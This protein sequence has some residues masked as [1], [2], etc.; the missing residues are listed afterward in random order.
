VSG[1]GDASA[2]SGSASVLVGAAHLE[3]LYEDLKNWGRWGAD[4]EL[5]ALNYVRAEHRVAAASLVEIGTTISLSRAMSPTLTRENPY[6]VQHHMLLA[7]DARD[8]TGIP[9]YEAS[10]D[11]LGT[12]V[13]ALGVTHIDAL[14]HIFV[15]NQMYN[16]VPGTEV[17]S[18]GAR[19]NSVGALS[20]GIVGRGVLLDAAAARGMAYLTS[21]ATVGVADLEAAEARQDVR[22]GEGDLLLVST[23]RDA[24][25][26]A[27]GGVLDPDVHG[28]T[29]LDP[30]CL[31]WMHERRVALLGC[32]GISDPLPGLAVPEWPFPI[33]QIGISAMGLHLI[34][35]MA[36]DALARQCQSIGRW[37]FLLV[38]SPLRVDGG[39]GCPVNPLAVL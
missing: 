32:D 33:H 39:T 2:T 20:G 10:R 22:A 25:R 12:R 8:G 15:R 16:G 9:G 14:C 23:G 30:A 3:Q 27:E 5:G 31:P 37:S 34:D 38:I 36:L 19:R 17:R 28:M 11:Y 24:L 6:P 7:G 4:D 1:H 18:D 35:N 21:D 26:D 29:G 13:H